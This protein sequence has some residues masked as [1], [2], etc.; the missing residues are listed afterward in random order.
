MKLT[1]N[2]RKQ[3]FALTYPCELT[4]SVRATPNYHLPLRY[5]SMCNHNQHSFAMCG[6]RSGLAPSWSRQRR[7]T[8]RPAAAAA[9]TQVLQKA[10]VL[11]QRR[12]SEPTAAPT[13]PAADTSRSNNC[14]STSSVA[15]TSNRSQP[16]KTVQLSEQQIAGFEDSFNRFSAQCGLDTDWNACDAAAAQQYITRERFFL[17]AGRND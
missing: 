4:T 17:Q 13:G 16:I 7:A 2:K 5:G 6:K 8:C 14:D 10:P 15:G 1:A 12:P 9:R 3:N 11:L